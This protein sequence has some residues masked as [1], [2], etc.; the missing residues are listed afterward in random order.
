MLYNKVIIQKHPPDSYTGR[1][2]PRVTMSHFKG[3]CQF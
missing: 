1:F 2:N 3:S